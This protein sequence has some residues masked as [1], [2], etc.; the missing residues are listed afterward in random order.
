[1]RSLTLA[2]AQHHLAYAYEGGDLEQVPQELARGF[3]VDDS[4]VAFPASSSADWPVQLLQAEL[5]AIGV[6]LRR[7]LN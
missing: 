7:P 4:E 1:M 3:L 2:R 5:Y 6:Q